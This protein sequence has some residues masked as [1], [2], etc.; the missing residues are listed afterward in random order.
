MTRHGDPLS[1]P[2]EASGRL[3]GPPVFKTGERA[4]ARWRVRFPSASARH[5]SGGGPAL[6]ATHARFS[7]PFAPDT[8]TSAR[9][10]GVDLA[11]F[12][13][14]GPEFECDRYVARRGPFLVAPLVFRELG[15]GG[16]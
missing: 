4:R 15:L 14:A 6:I 1:L 8:Q 9:D 12:R 2:A 5:L 16:S 13:R 7:Y 10:T 11:P 3:V